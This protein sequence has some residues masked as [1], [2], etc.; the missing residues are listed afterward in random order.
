MRNVYKTVLSQ[1]VVN[2]AF[3]ANCGI[4]EIVS[5]VSLQGPLSGMRINYD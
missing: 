5:C 4:V 1:G 2:P 3:I